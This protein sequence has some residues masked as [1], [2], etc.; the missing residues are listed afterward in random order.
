MRTLSVVFGQ[1]YKQL[2]IV[3][4]SVGSLALLPT[5]ALASPAPAP[6]FDPASPSAFLH[7]TDTYTFSVLP[8]TGATS[9]GFEFFQDQNGD[10]VI[11]DGENLGGGLAY[12][13]S[14]TTTLEIN[15]LNP[16][17]SQIK[18]GQLKVYAWT[19]N[20][21]EVS[22][23]NNP[24]KYVDI[25]N[26][27]NVP[28]LSPTNPKQFILGEE[29]YTFEVLPISGMTYYLF[30]FTQDLNGDGSLNG[31]DKWP[32]SER[33]FQ[34]TTPRL[35]IDKNTPLYSKI[36]AGKLHA[37]IHA[38]NYNNT[39]STD[40]L[41]IDFD[42]V[43][44]APS[45]GAGTACNAFDLNNDGIITYKDLK[46]I[47]DAYD[48]G[49]CAAAS[50]KSCDLIKDNSAPFIDI[51]PDLNGDGK[52]T[53]TD[54]G[55][56]DKVAN[57]SGNTPN[58]PCPAGKICD[59][60]NDG[61]VDA[62]D[63]SIYG[64]Y[65][66]KRFQSFDLNNDG[67]VDSADSDYVINLL[68][69]HQPCPTGKACNLSGG[70]P[71]VVS[72]SDSGRFVDYVLKDL[73]GD[74]FVDQRDVDRLNQVALGNVSCSL[75]KKCDIDG[76]GAVT[77]YDVSALVSYIESLGSYPLDLNN[78]GVVD[79]G[80]SQ[81]LLIVNAGQCPFGKI[82]DING[83]DSVDIFDN[84]ALSDFIALDLNNDGKVDANDRDLLYTVNFT[85]PI[86]KNCDLAKDGQVISDMDRFNFAVYVVDDFTYDGFLDQRDV[87]RLNQIVSGSL[88]CPLHQ[89]CDL[90]SDGKVD[91][92]DV[93]KLADFIK[94]IGGPAVTT[95]F[96]APAIN[97]NA[98]TI[99]DLQAMQNELVR[100]YDYTGD[101]ALT[102]A[103]VTFLTGMSASF[104]DIKCPPGKLC[105]VDKNGVEATANDIALIQE[106]V[107]G[108]TNK[109]DLNGDGIIDNLDRKI[110]EDA[111]SKGFC[112]VGAGHTC[113]LDGNGVTNAS[114]LQSIKTELIRLYD[115]TGDGALDNADYRFLINMSLSLGQTACPAGRLCDINGN[116][117]VAD[118]ADITILQNIIYVGPTVVITAPQFST[119][120]EVGKKYTIRWTSNNVVG[121]VS[122]DIARGT[123]A[124]TEKFSSVANING[125]NSFD[126]NVSETLALGK[127][128]SIT[129]TSASTT[130]NT[131]AVIKGISD[132]FAVVPHSA[133]TVTS[134]AEDANWA[135]GSKQ[136]ITWKSTGVVGDTVEIFLKR[137][138]ANVGSLASLQDP[139]QEPVPNQDGR[140]SFSWTLNQSFLASGSGYSVVVRDAISH[141]I[142]GESA[143]FAI[144]PEPKKLSSLSFT[145][146]TKIFTIGK[147]TTSYTATFTNKG[148]KTLSDLTLAAHI[149]Q[150]STNGKKIS[151][152]SATVETLIQC[153][154]LN[155][156]QLD[157]GQCVSAD[158]AQSVSVLADT[159][160]FRPGSA[161]FVVE[162]KSG[163]TLST[164][165]IPT[166]FYAYDLNNDGKVDS[167][168]SDYILNLLNNVEPCPAGKAC[169]M[170][171]GDPSFV[172]NT[173]AARF[174][175]Y[176]W[177]DLNSDGL[178]NQ[179]DIDLLNQVVVG[180]ASCPISK[181][182]DANADGVVDSADVAKFTDY[183]AS[184][185][186]NK[187]GTIIEKGGTTVLLQKTKTIQLLALPAIFVTTPGGGEKWDLESKQ[188][189]KWSSIG[190][191]GNV[192]IALKQINLKY[193]INNDGK[194]DSADIAYIQDLSLVDGLCPAGKAC[195]AT[196]DGPIIT[197][198]DV[199]AFTSYIFL[200]LNSDGFLNQQDTDILN[201]VIAGTAQCPFGKKCNFSAS[202]LSNENDLNNDGKIT[203]AD[204]KVLN[205]VANLT[206]NT[207]NVLCPSG[208]VCDLNYDGKVDSIDS[209]KYYS[210][211]LKPFQSYDLNSDGK[212][213]VSDQEYINT[214]LQAG[215]DCPSGKDCDPTKAG[216][217]S[218]DANSSSNFNSYIIHDLNSDGF[219]NQ[220]DVDLLNQV[221]IG[222]M[223]C[224][225][226]KNCDLNSSGSVND[227]DVMNLISYITQ[228]L[229]GTAV[230]KSVISYG[231]VI[232]TDIRNRN[233]GTY[234]WTI[235][236]PFAVAGT[237]YIIQ[238][239][240]SAKKDV[241][242]ESGVFDITVPAPTITSPKKNKSFTISDNMNIVVDATHPYQLT[243]YRIKLYQDSQTMLYESDPVNLDTL[244]FNIDQYL[245]RKSDSKK[246]TGLLRDGDLTISLEGQLQ[247]KSFTRPAYVTVK[248]S[249]NRAAPRITKP[250]E[251]Q[252]INL[253]K[254]SFTIAATHPSN[255]SSYRVA[256]Y[257][258][259]TLKYSSAVDADA[260]GLQLVLDRN[261]TYQGTNVFRSFD[262][263]N[264]LLVVQG[265]LLDG[266]TA[267]ARRTFKVVA[268]PPDYDLNDDGLINSQDLAILQATIVYDSALRKAVDEGRDAS[269]VAKPDLIEPCV[270]LTRSK[271]KNCNFYSDFETDASK[272]SKDMRI[273]DSRDAAILISNGA[274]VSG[275]A[276][277]NSGSSTGGTPTSGSGA[278]AGWTPITV[279]SPNV[280]NRWPRG[281]PATIVWR[282]GG[283]SNVALLLNTPD[284]NSTISTIASSIPNT[285]S[286]QWAIPS[287]L[288]T[289]FYS[290][291]V[292]CRLGSECPATGWYADSASFFEIY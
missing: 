274:F 24:V 246:V 227:I 30:W 80:D 77:K 126:W 113:D 169:N 203:S 101:S 124:P 140:N 36:M 22:L 192:D 257:Q 205:D 15:A 132:T 85:C 21:N 258:N 109:F 64:L 38:I 66:L 141:G 149:E 122:I 264:V 35:V 162:L 176:I 137:N 51:A 190:D 97:S 152:K 290:I 115:Y 287:N 53:S 166:D 111:I 123:K 1:F 76:D 56:L 86:S 232:A 158:P 102:Q 54:K 219:V 170:S 206:G 104:G 147:T 243:R 67:K 153:P 28:I 103:D 216:I 282:G 41:E 49:T 207:P 143:L 180:T 155:A 273:I 210:D 25:K 160:Q 261:T 173:D 91:G 117:K 46:I 252:E 272:K 100:L 108:G 188:T 276:P 50:G 240:D 17:Y 6:I 222:S 42:I 285:G 270:N 253:G 181:K 68:T 193:D 230:S 70:D 52:I 177:K 120:V 271:P 211:I 151:G 223:A 209:N 231:G 93:A 159:G 245:L 98:Y 125:A 129:I 288:A 263:G 145:L 39:V 178:V 2:L 48:T 186:S 142:L 13:Y 146:D 184:I 215:E 248:V 96:V 16:L 171:G 167:A 10:G 47:Q 256:L 183:V 121:P 251:G 237:G 40:P 75:G 199:S 266:Y 168:D 8:V 79:N 229:G 87:D 127:D 164:T 90:N 107:K 74:G 150:L 172:S 72:S 200:D 191:V 213:D 82:C 99:A 218:I 208:K 134:P 260:S 226:S 154:P 198:F 250:G 71:T 182:C 286:Y 95:N 89:R 244:Q 161:Q 128:Y 197:S 7:N 18:L 262:P 11:G 119:N 283:L 277:A 29:D 138:G 5:M 238:V 163:A 148:I 196:G 179:L 12:A 157:S 236:Q 62:K 20:G 269:T 217:N 65:V 60:N 133:I 32:T 228:T 88:S 156:G 201:K 165:N 131:G 27:L 14:T 44:G 292:A 175:N 110:I 23:V 43:V 259:N 81:Y 114:D 241:I 34:I 235:N 9:Y 3:F 195:D 233:G 281:L 78:D 265:K 189:I 130:S 289:G 31:L 92:A 61:V 187:V 19:A 84:R 83:D 63:S 73:N 254:G 37:Q 202:A 280:G 194:I 239:Y 284:N 94:S 267:E 33:F 278:P 249:F 105:D 116:G 275:T 279:I 204:R 58:F 212:V 185:G 59:M 4:V 247:D 224:P 139:S 225:V 214:L 255:P 45:C 220:R 55:I 291:R 136:K 174:L 221:V 112:D 234:K 135:E 26:R 69:A 57:L 106:F 268:M 144:S 118:A 242:G